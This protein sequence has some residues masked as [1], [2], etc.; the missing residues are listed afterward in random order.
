MAQIIL[1]STL[2]LLLGNKSNTFEHLFK[3]KYHHLLNRTSGV[4]GA[5]M[6]FKVF[7]KN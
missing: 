7:K 4:L 3:I 5:L 6:V 2:T 1:M